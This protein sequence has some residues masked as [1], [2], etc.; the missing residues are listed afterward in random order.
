MQQKLVARLRYA[1]GLSGS[2][3]F[4]AAAKACGVFRPPGGGG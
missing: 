1:A 4:A 3:R 2:P